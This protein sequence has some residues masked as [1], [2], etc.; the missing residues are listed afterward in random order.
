MATWKVQQDDGTVSV[1]YFQR[2]QVT[3]QRCGTGDSRLL[4]DVLAWCIDTAAVADV[5]VVGDA[6]FARLPPPGAVHGRTLAS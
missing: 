3:P 6:V 2:G 4:P 1:L 5:I